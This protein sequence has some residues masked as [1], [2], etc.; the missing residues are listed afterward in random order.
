MGFVIRVIVE[1]LKGEVGMRQKAIL[2]LGLFFIFLWGIS[3]AQ[4]TP[5]QERLKDEYLKQ[6]GGNAPA[7]AS[8]D[9]IEKYKSPDD[10][11][12]QDSSFY[13]PPVGGQPPANVVNTT[14]STQS[15]SADDLKLFGYNMFDGSPESFSPVL[16]STPPPDYKLGPGDNILVNIWGRVDMQ[17]DLTV[18][19]EG[20]IFIPKA[21]E[22]IAWGMTLDEFNKRIESKLSA[23]YSDFKYSVTLGKIRRIKVFVYGEVK[24]PGA[25]TTSSLATLFNALYLAGG[26]TQTGSLRLVKHIRNNQAIWQIDLYRFLIE[27]D[28]SQDSKLESGDVIF[29]PVV[30]P[31][32]RISGQV[33][34]PAIYEIKGGETITSL[35]QLAGGTTAESFMEM[36][37]V[38]R[39][40]K[41]DSRIIKDVNLS[42]TL[43]A[44]NPAA[45]QQADLALRDGD[46]LWIPSVFEMRK[47]TVKLTGNVKHPSTF[48]L[49]DSMK[50]SNLIDKG[51]QLK[52]DTYLKRA[53][54]FR[55]LPDQTREV[56][57]VNIEEIL[58]GVDSTDY[59][60]MD[61]DSLVVYSQQEMKR[62]MNVTIYGAVKHPG[63]YEYFDNMRLSDLIFLGGNPLKQSY[64]L[65]AEI[66]R[67][68]PGKPADMLYANLDK[69]LNEKDSSDDVLLA[70]DD[71][72]FIRT[73]PRWRLENNVTIE[74]EVMFPGTYAITK[75]D[76]KLLDII[77]RSG[78]LTPD[79]FMDGIVYMRNTISQD[80]EKRQVRAIL[81]STELTILDSLNRPLPKLSTGID[82]SAAN[83]III[84]TRELL[85]NP[86]SPSNITLLNG[87]YIFIPHRQSG[88]QVLGAVAS[89]GTIAFRDGKTAGYFIKSAGG[90]CRNAEK[91]QTRLA[92]SSGKVFAGRQAFSS[93]VDPGDMIIVPQKIKRE[94]GSWFGS[95]TAIA[96]IITSL[97][98]AVLITY[99]L[100]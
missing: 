55:T 49:A 17:L 95:A 5:E 21:G 4:L 54:L 15:T 24:R 64:M 59:K 7:P 23:I 99:K 76:E 3:A 43:K 35:I 75:E 96:A 81:A 73:I 79:A 57:P 92:K 25:Y 32:V 62:Q 58:S 82:L 40:S 97:T 56:Y 60:L 22:I 36:V 67:I 12:A 8:T 84:D 19:R 13:T 50:V 89:T 68:N 69:V 30:G 91:G 14:G 11:R 74:G 20:K 86:K 80:I 78:G 66:A 100:K 27:G 85:K 98:T 45:Y 52:V 1:N 51:E 46:R 29:V 83:R 47:N 65:Q 33:K 18:D 72:V 28:N 88:V 37:S 87:D 38:E 2:I 61:K 48:G 39:I 16:E 26:P 90:F 9:I 31:L 71:I 44:S 77:G 93:K 42:D 53:N 34:R 6:N 41:D 94:R 63:T 10:F 70:E